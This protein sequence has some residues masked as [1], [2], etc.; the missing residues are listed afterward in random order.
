MVAAKKRRTLNERGVRAVQ[1]ERIPA[2]CD[3]KFPPLYDEEAAYRFVERCVWPEGPVCPHCGGS[4]RIGRMNGRSTRTGTYKCYECRKP[5]TVKVGT[6][7]ESSNLAMH[8]WLQAILLLRCGRESI[9]V[10]ELHRT[11]GV[12]LRT[13]WFISHRVN[14]GDSEQLNRHCSSQ[15]GRA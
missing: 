2:I 1:F 5:F 11:L 10:N 15:P 12:A 6:I 13:A 3:K 7:F 9:D 14:I 4:K 8:K